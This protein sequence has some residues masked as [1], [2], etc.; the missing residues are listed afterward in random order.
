MATCFENLVKH[1][2]FVI[3]EFEELK[4]NDKFVDCD[5]AW[6]LLNRIEELYLQVFDD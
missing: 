6:E 2:E 4:K 1:L 3:R 5:V